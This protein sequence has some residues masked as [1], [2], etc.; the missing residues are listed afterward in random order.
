MKKCLLILA[1]LGFTACGSLPEEH[2]K[3]D[4]IGGAL[5]A[6]KDYTPAVGYITP[7]GSLCSG[8]VVDDFRM[9]TAAHCLTDLYG[10]LKK[11][12]ESGNFLITNFTSK[13]I[14]QPWLWFESK[15]SII[16]IHPTFDDACAIL[17]NCNRPR[18]AGPYIDIAVISFQKKLPEKWGRAKID[19]STVLLGDA[20]TPVGYGCE[21]VAQRQTNII[22]K[23]SVDLRAE[24]SIN[25][26]EPFKVDR[27]S[28]LDKHFFLTMNKNA[29]KPTRVCPGD[30]GGPI[31]RTGTNYVVGII[32]G[33]VTPT[34]D[35][36]FSWSIYSR[37]NND[38]GFVPGSTDSNGLKLNN[39]EFLDQ[40]VDSIA[41]DNYFY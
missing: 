41:F 4:L 37:I 24:L 7:T 10:K 16:D 31:F 8:V 19:T 36:N 21:S 28:S 29:R 14:S 9:L 25:L 22:N 2:S 35:S 40:H 3:Q 1:S 39:I 18:S 26:P 30:S 12:N 34:M 17:G 5:V 13:N 32:K 15:A 33:S 27:D 23:K 38:V 11:A 6:K 20:V